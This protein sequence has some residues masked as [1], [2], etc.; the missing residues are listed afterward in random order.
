VCEA[1]SEST[2]IKNY[3]LKWRQSQNCCENN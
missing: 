2:R 1:E 3:F